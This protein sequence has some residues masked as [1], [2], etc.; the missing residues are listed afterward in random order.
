MREISLTQGC[1]AL[2]DDADYEWLSQWKWHAIKDGSGYRAARRERKS[3]SG[4]RKIVYMA[5]QIMKAE[6]EEL[7][8]HLNHRTLDNQRGNLRRCTH[9]QNQANRRK[10]AGCSSQFKGVYW[11]K[12]GKKWAAGV[13]V[14]GKLKYLGLFV[15]EAD[16]ARRYNAEAVQ[17]FGEFALLND[18]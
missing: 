6:Q 2:V 10:I 14:A 1:I 17:E 11:H 15:D 18:V 3:E 5:R 13:R 4:T 16:A 12:R 9:A 8:D 7:V